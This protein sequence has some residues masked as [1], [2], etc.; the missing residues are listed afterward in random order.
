MF[1][2]HDLLHV[3]L[4]SNTNKPILFIDENVY[5][6]HLFTFNA[7]K[8]KLV[9]IGSINIFIYNIYNETLKNLLH[10]RSHLFS[11]FIFI[12]TSFISFA[13]SCYPILHKI[14]G[15][16]TKVVYKRN[17]LFIYFPPTYCRVNFFF[18]YF[19]CC[20]RNIFLIDSLHA[21]VNGSM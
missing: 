18:V 15:K 11:V 4:R 19:Y 17:I 8:K 13:Y 3:I 6:V 1:I 20:I 10:K 9:S 7:R 2:I 16:I 5:I 14:L 21:Y 12:P